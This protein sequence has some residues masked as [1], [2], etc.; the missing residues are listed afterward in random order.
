MIVSFH[1]QALDEYIYWQN[2]DRKTLKRI[3]ALLQ[4]ILRNGVDK[5]IVKPEPRKYCP[6]WSR[7]IDDAN[8]LVYEVQGDI[9]YI[10][11]CK[12]HYADK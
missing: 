2:Q 10:F 5:G 6:G 7:R 11:A 4:D 1:K 8:R 9:L 3:N 12:G